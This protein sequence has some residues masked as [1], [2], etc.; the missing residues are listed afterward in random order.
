MKTTHTYTISNETL[1]VSRMPLSEL[2]FNIVH[3]DVIIHAQFY[4]PSHKSASM[5][6][7]TVQR[8]WNRAQM[9][10]FIN[11]KLRL[12]KQD[13]Q[14]DAQGY[15]SIPPLLVEVMG[16]AYKGRHVRLSK[17]FIK[18]YKGLYLVHV[19]IP[20]GTGTSFLRIVMLGRYERHAFVSYCRIKSLSAY[21][22]VFPS[23]LS[24][25][26]Q[27]KLLDKLS[28]IERK[29]FAE[30]GP[31]TYIQSMNHPAVVGSWLLS[32]QAT[33][34]QV[35]SIEQYNKLYKQEVNPTQSGYVEQSASSA[36]AIKPIPT[37][38]PLTS[39]GL[40]TVSVKAL[41]SSFVVHREE[42]LKFLKTSWK[43]P[44]GEKIQSALAKWH[45]ERYLS[46]PNRLAIVGIIPMNR[47]LDPHERPRDMTANMEEL[48]IPV[49]GNLIVGAVCFQF[50]DASATHRQPSRK[51]SASNRTRPN[52]HATTPVRVGSKR[53]TPSTQRQSSTRKQSQR[54]KPSGGTSHA[55]S[56]KT[57][58]VPKQSTI[59]LK[60]MGV[61]YSYDEDAREVFNDRTSKK[62]HTGIKYRLIRHALQCAKH[63]FGE[64]P[65]VFAGKDRQT[66]KALTRCHFQQKAS[67][68]FSLSSNKH[69][70]VLVYG[71]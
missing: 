14:T 42:N 34:V 55:H 59:E 36:P 69:H 16:E 7:A 17:H 48:H 27:R 52:S 10:G 18:Q 44:K 28:I 64:H 70:K 62:Q 46:N 50:H 29:Q 47:Y 25:A 24:L 63:V 61:D 67:T 9:K 33:G 56:R 3:N 51:Q 6:S 57:N 43:P 19:D 68:N 66:K 65:I 5:E 38:E 22:L 45:L 1:L 12:S 4:I 37:C 71:D 53:K 39:E 21:V 49:A 26:E 2:S 20:S 23:F 35:V 15:I 30:L 60:H 13:T 11:R 40:E 32:M 31:K 8:V 58:S 41:D 54:L